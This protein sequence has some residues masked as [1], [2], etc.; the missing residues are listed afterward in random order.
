MCV[1]SDNNGIGK[2]TVFSCGKMARFL[3]WEVLE[4]W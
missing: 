4:F 1:I 3:K 2:Q